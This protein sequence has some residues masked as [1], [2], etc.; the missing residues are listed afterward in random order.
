MLHAMGAL[1]VGVL[2]CRGRNFRGVMLQELEAYA[3]RHHLVDVPTVDARIVRLAN[4]NIGS[5]KT[6]SP[7]VNAKINYDL[8]QGYNF[9]PVWAHRFFESKFGTTTTEMQNVTDLV[10]KGVAGTCPIVVIGLPPNA[11]FVNDELA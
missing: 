3:N 10:E 11:I 2:I 5:A 8:D 4:H 1:D 9:A 6:T 7:S